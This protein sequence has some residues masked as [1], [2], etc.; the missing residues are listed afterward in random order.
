M[1]TASETSPVAGAQ[2]PKAQSKSSQCPEQAAA[3][4]PQYILYK[5]AHIVLSKLTAQG[6]EA[7]ESC[8]VLCTRAGAQEHRVKWS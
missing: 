8:A 4:W 1:I 7:L 2:L 5:H 6:K 3:H